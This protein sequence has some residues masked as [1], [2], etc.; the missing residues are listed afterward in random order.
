M[1]PTPGGHRGMGLSGSGM[2]PSGPV[3]GSDPGMLSPP[4][5]ILVAHGLK[6]AVLVGKLLHSDVC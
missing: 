5:K 6:V 3:S 4:S 2:K 1:P